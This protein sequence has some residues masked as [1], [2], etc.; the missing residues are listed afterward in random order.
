MK[1]APS[2]D[3]QV[4]CL[5]FQEFRLFSGSGRSYSGAGIG[6]QAPA[7][8][9][10]LVPVN[11]AALGLSEIIWK[12][13]SAISIKTPHLRTELDIETPEALSRLY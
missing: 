4:V 3:W 9:L 6:K 8:C 2:V 7:L 1:W 10:P 13:V 11:P 12:S 5:I